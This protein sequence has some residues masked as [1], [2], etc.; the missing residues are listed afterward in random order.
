MTDT[1]TP[2]HGTL[3][4][5]V[6]LRRVGIPVSVDAPD[7]ADFV[8]MVRVRNAV[9][10]ELDGN[11]D[12]AN[13][14]E[15]ILPNYQRQTYER[16]LIWI[17][18]LDGDVVGRAN[19]VLPMEEGSRVAFVNIEL[20]RRA[21]GRGIGGAVADVLERAAADEGRSVLQAWATH[22][23]DD[24]ARVSAPTGFG[25]VPLDHTA[26]F[27]TA[28]GYALEQIE[29][30]SALELTD[31][32]YAHVDELL[33]D[34]T[35]AAQGY[36]TVQ[37]TAPTP[38]EHVDGYAR[39]KARMATDAPAAGM[40]FDEERWDAAR[41]AD[42]EA[43]YLAAGRTLHVTAAQ[44][45]VSGELVA[46]NELVIGADRREATHQEDTLVLAE[47]RGHRL[48]MLVKCA[49]L[50]DWRSFAPDSPRVITYNAEENRPML[51][52]NEAIGF[53]PIAYN[54]A[55]KK[56]VTSGAGSAHRSD[57]SGS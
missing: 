38:P 36:R 28:H 39:V 55:W 57:S 13:T 12:E 50:H 30:K 1:M 48:G 14:P 16:N 34:A 22:T 19:L 56:T 20:L 42:H 10:R 45:V 43:P 11:D 52:I 51:D 27:L 35:R 21:W 24:A 29:R 4:V 3:P 33:A 2:P 6:E 7:A 25:S 32:A 18:L 46:F 54:G 31:A 41:I 37:W 47:H 40:E 44:H 9:Y 49:A 17:A 8:A 15:E 26:R 53:A 5:G 23:G